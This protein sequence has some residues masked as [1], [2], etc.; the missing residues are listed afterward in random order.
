M[1][2]DYFEQN[3][4]PENIL[5]ESELQSIML[6]CKGIDRCGYFH[7]SNKVAF[8]SKMIEY[9]WI[10]SDTSWNHYAQNR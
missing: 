4:V 8:H 9:T 1:E 7:L 3:V 6:Y 2:L 5:T 10:A